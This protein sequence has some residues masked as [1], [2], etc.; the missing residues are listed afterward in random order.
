M[1]FFA[2]IKMFHANSGLGHCSQLIFTTH[3]TNLL[4][5]ELFRRD[6][7]W[8]T[9]KDNFGATKLYSLYD[10][11]PQNKRIRTDEM[12]E[13]NY[14]IGKYGAIPYIGTLRI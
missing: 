3:D 4:S 14:L 1:G 2:L 12:Y 7:I 10:Y 11:K 8:F 13:K 9:E 5:S 6:Q